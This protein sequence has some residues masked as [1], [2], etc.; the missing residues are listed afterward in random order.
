LSYIRLCFPFF[1]SLFTFSLQI[2]LLN[3]FCFAF[4]PEVK[5]LWFV[6]QTKGKKNKPLL[7]RSKVSWLLCC[8][9]EDFRLQIFLLRRCFVEAKSLGKA[10]EQ[11]NKQTRGKAKE[12]KNKQTK[13][14]LTVGKKAT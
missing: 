12:Q 9:K 7:R 1:E 3:F 8:S 10:K 13:A 2:F 11:K 14:F 6:K 4:L 5:R